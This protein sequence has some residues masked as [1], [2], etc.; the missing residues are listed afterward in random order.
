M[1]I[2]NYLWVYVIAQIYLKKNLNKLFNSLEYVRTYIDD[3]LIVNNKSFDDK[4]LNKLK[5]TGFIENTVKSFFA[6]NELEY[7]GFRVTRQGIMPL[8]DKV[9]A[10]K[11]IAVPTT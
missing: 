6:R 11:N 3:I 8:P 10:V 4:V 9:E 2:K 5:Q 1:N 7:L